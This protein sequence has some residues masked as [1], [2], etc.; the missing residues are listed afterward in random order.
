[1]ALDKRKKK[2]KKIKIHCP[3]M[4]ADTHEWR[5]EMAL[6]KRNKK[7]KSHCPIMCADTDEWRPEMAL[8]KRKKKKIHCPSTSILY[9]SAYKQFTQTSQGRLKNKNAAAQQKKNLKS[10]WRT[11]WYMKF[12]LGTLFRISAKGQRWC[13]TKKNISKTFLEVIVQ[14][15]L[16][17]KVPG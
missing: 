5:P 17:Y 11:N 3:I 8:E 7:K 14:V 9:K 13:L 16:R 12:R 6:E 2:E 4:C 15:Q 10:Q 1:M